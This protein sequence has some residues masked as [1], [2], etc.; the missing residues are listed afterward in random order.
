M[1]DNFTKDQRNLIK[2]AIDLTNE[3][4]FATLDQASIV[5]GYMTKFASHPEI[6]VQIFADISFKLYI[7]HHTKT[8]K[9]FLKLQHFFAILDDMQHLLDTK[10]RHYFSLILCQLKMA[11]PLIGDDPVLANLD[12]ELLQMRYKKA[13]D[14]T[15]FFAYAMKINSY[16]AEIPL[17][18]Q[19]FVQII[20]IHK[21]KS[22]ESQPSWEYIEPIFKKCAAQIKSG[23][24]TQEIGQ[25]FN[26][27]FY[28]G[29]GKKDD[30]LES[31]LK[32]HGDW[33]EK[34]YIEKLGRNEV[35]TEVA[36]RMRKRHFKNFLTWMDRKGKSDR[37]L[38]EKIVDSLEKTFWNKK[39]T[40][41]LMM[42]MLNQFAKTKKSPADLIE[43][44]DQLQNFA[45]KIKFE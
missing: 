43:F 45:K 17:V 26:S 40:V 7:I 23:S 42:P 28:E 21:A 36:A 35:S 24:T 34:K 5:P 33:S 12:N 11:Y 44:M 13:A 19:K 30:S 39:P 6:L 15:V 8:D 3:F 25:I 27:Y 18:M 41:Q 16:L 38:E 2:E 10:D 1:T 22:I 32:A 37:E 4:P 20:Y 9:D 14:I 31:Q 29:K